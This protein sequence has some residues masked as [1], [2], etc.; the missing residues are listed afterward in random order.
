MKKRKVSYQTAEQQIE[1]IE[2]R[3]KIVSTLNWDLSIFPIKK[4]GIDFKTD[5]DKSR[6]FAEVFTPLHI[7]DEMIQTIPEGG[8]TQIT[9]NLDLCAGYGQFS[10]RIIRKLYEDHRYDFKLNN[11][12]HDYHFFNELQISSCYK[13]LWIFGI[14]INL[15]IGDA[16]Q[17]GKLPA[18][19]KGVWLYVKGIDSWMDVT[20]LVKKLFNGSSKSY[21]KNK[22]KKFVLA[23][24][25][26]INRIGYEREH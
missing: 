9:R 13:L 16:L 11:Y 10:I 20:G 7:V 4:N 12:L 25:S 19:A 8:M 5:K 21:N 18:K 26:I 23:F 3:F 6:E 1:G 17:L 15:A 2:S 22:E 14:D 24:D